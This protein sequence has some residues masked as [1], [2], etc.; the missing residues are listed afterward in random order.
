[1]S[2]G[3]NVNQELMTN[4]ARFSGGQSYDLNSS[5]E[6]RPNLLT[7]GVLMRQSYALTFK[8]ELVADDAA[9][10]LAITLDYQ[11]TTATAQSTFTGVPGEVVVEGPGIS[12]G[13]T[14]RGMVFL[15]AD[16]QAPAAVKTV[17]FLLDNQP[18]AELTKPPYRFD[19]DSTSA[20]PGTHTLTV[21]AADVAGNRRNP[22]DGQRGAATAGGH[23]RHAGPHCGPPPAPARSPSSPKRPRA[24]QIW[25]ARSSCWRWSSPVCGCARCAQHRCR[26]TCQVEL[27]TRQLAQPL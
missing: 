10:P 12:N 16:V 21:R 25:A 26:S 18:L 22:G 11:G 27:V 13:Q 6:I 14:V 24:G 1:M 8:S 3:P 17:S 20:D 23:H 2:F 19:W 5:A 9:H 4:W 7:L 15:V